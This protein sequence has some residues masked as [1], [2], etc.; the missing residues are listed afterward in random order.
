MTPDDRVRRRVA[1]FGEFE[2]DLDSRELFKD[3]VK[4]RLADQPF[5]LLAVLL[6]RVGEVVT[7]DELRRRLWPE[8]THVEFDRSLNTAASRLL[9]GIQPIIL[10]ISRHS[11]NGGTDSPL[12]CS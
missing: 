2:A 8:D 9:W 11:Q 1:R 7:R 6:Q 10:A 3:G 4:V 12:P 5:Q